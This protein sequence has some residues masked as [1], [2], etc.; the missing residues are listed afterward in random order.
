MKYVRPGSLPR[1]KNPPVTEV[2]IGVALQ[3]LHIPVTELP[4]LFAAFEHDYPERF[5]A[6]PR[7]VEL[8]TERVRA[9]AFRIELAD[10]PAIPRIRFADVE[11]SRWIEVQSDSL[12]C[13]WRK[14]PDKPYPDY[15]FLREEFE[16]I[17]GVFVSFWSQ[18]HEEEDL[19]IIQ[20]NVNYYNDFHVPDADG[21]MDAMCRAFAMQPEPRAFNDLPPL[22]T[23]GLSF[24]FDFADD[25]GQIYA[26]LTSR[27]AVRQIDGE[28][29]ARLNLSFTGDPYQSPHS[30][31]L[32]ALDGTLAFI[33]KGHDS[34][35][36]AFCDTTSAQFHK[37]WGRYET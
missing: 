15:E 30:A 14:A 23:A 36:R 9:T 26:I 35:V 2:R 12:T 25:D 3:P 16:R 24:S 21:L 29:V 28:H 34:I 33:D 8:V 22:D 20:A 1:F 37:V 6:P 19:Y 4:A 13:G 17:A 27:A 31:E 10:V 32:N 11:R 18:K 7:P 5:E